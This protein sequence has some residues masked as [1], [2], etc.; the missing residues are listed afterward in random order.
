M[1]SRNPH[2][3][4]AD[5]AENQDINVVVFSCKGRFDRSAISNIRQY[6][7]GKAINIIHSHNY[8]SNF[9]ARMALPQRGVRWLVTNHGRRSGGALLML[10]TLLDTLVMRRADKIV[11]VSEQI[12]RHLHQAGLSREQLC[13]IDNGINPYNYSTR[14]PAS[15]LRSSLGLK[16]DAVLIGTVAALTKEKG[17]S[18]LLEAIPEVVSRFPEAVFLFVGDGPER[19]K[20]ERIAKELNVSKNTVF[21][22]I[23]DDVPEILATL[24]AFVLPSLSEGLPIALLEAQA[25]QVPTVATCVGAIPRVID[26]KTTGILVPPKSSSALS[27]AICGVLEDP[28]SA[29]LMTS[30]GFKRLCENFSSKAMTGRYISLYQQVLSY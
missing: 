16:H 29:S 23:R 6:V 30:K 17:H 1:N 10:Y 7:C 12:L 11:T 3:E 13:V 18:Y 24:S 19:K 25:A 9:Y 28:Q 4:V 5:A 15:G 20:L 26:D 2:L 22:G 27:E 8:K 14:Q 21:T